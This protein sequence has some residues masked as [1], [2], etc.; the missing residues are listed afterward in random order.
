MNNKEALLKSYEILSPYSDKQKW[1]FSSNL[2]HLNF[3]TARIKKDDKILD[4]GCGIGILALAFRLLGYNI[5]GVDK[6]VFKLNNEFFSGDLAK[7]RQ[8]WLEYGLNIIDKDILVD[9]IGKK[10]HVVISIA[11]LEHQKNIKLFLGKLLNYLENGGFIYIDT[12]NVANLLNRFRFLCGRS[13]LGNIE[14][15]FRGGE[16][17]NGHWREYSM[18]EVK[19][20]SK[21]SG[22]NIIQ[23]VNPQTQMAK[24]DLGSPRRTYLN[25]FRLLSLLVPGARDANIIWGQ[26]Q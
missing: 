17:F 15:F 5:E 1:E 2:Y 24:L 16:D 22:I 7:L 23:A 20:M 26:K 19:K 12:P 8:I 6:Y 14:D 10:Y 25:L 13:P 4:A 18:E 21:L 11:T 3:L 9:E